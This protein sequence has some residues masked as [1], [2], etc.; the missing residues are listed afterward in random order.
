MGTKPKT[1]A[2]NTQTHTDTQAHTDTPTD[3]VKHGAHTDERCSAL[4]V[5]AIGC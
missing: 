2:Q 5:P 4:S 1:K 3:L